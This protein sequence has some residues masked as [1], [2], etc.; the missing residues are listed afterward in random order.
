MR[1]ST[2]ESKYRCN[3]CWVI[4]LQDRC[5]AALDELLG[6]SHGQAFVVLQRALH[7]HYPWIVDRMNE[8]GCDVDYVDSAVLDITPRMLYSV[9]VSSCLKSQR[10]TKTSQHIPC[11]QRRRRHTKI[12]K[13][14][15]QDSV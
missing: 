2:E 13:K 14:P 7:E 11:P 9:H 8:V 3:I 10:L 6:S 1:I 12:I 5:R 15:N 4:K